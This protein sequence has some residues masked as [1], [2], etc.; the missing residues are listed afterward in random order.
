MKA[1]LKGLLWMLLIA[2]LAMLGIYLSM[3]KGEHEDWNGH[4]NATEMPVVTEM[5]AEAEGAQD[6]EAVG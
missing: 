5:P 3:Q 6:V 4:I 2:A 1:F